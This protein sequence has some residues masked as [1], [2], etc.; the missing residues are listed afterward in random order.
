MKQIKCL[1]SLYVT[2]SLG[3]LLLFLPALQ[4]WTWA[5]DSPKIRLAV[6]GFEKRGQDIPIPDLELIVND[7]L[8]AFLVNTNSFEVVERQALEKVLKEQSLGQSGILDSES[9]AKVGQLLGVDVLITGTLTFLADT[10]EITARMI[11]SGDGTILGAAS[12][13]TTEEDEIRGKVEELAGMLRTKLS[14]TAGG[15][16]KE[17]LSESFD[18]GRVWTEQWD[19]DF[20]ETMPQTEKD[21]TDVSQ[22]DG[23][24]RISG[25]YRGNNEDRVF[26]IFP[27][28][29]QKYQSIEAGIRFRDVQGGAVV[30]L[31][32][33]W[34]E[35]EKWTGFCPYVEEGYSDLNIELD[36]QEEPFTFE[37]DI[38]S[39]QWYVIR[40]DYQNG[41]LSY[42]WEN[43]LIKRLA[44]EP[45]ISASDEISV[46]VT[47]VLEETRSFLFEIDRLILR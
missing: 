1:A 29:W 40:L 44:V 38:R 15:E 36:G 18:D 24:L 3:F 19:I 34:G 11:D 37:F 22:K 26:W 16:N 33:T 30:C 5:E 41:M 12:I 10:F 25:K 14:S 4:A 28:V 7:W 31:D 6:A 21:A 8:T 32:M 23:V 20:D 47:F 13:S 2:I 45:A 43:Q 39:D 42:Y 46:N 27:T 9:A 35:D 17:L